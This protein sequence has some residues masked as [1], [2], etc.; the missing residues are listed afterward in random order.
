[1]SLLDEAST[2]GVGTSSASAARILGYLRH[3]EHGHTLLAPHD[4]DQGVL[5]SAYGTGERA[6]EGVECWDGADVVVAADTLRAR[7]HP[8]QGP[9]ATRTS[10]FPIGAPDFSALQFYRDERD[11]SSLAPRLSRSQCP[12]LWTSAVGPPEGCDYRDVGSA[13]E[14]WPWTYGEDVEAGID[15]DAEWR[16]GVEMPELALLG[17]PD[18]PKRAPSTTMMRPPAATTRTRTGV[19]EG[20]NV[21]RTRGCPE[22]SRDEIETGGGARCYTLE[23]VFVFGDVC[24][25]GCGSRCHERRKRYT[26]TDGCGG[27]SVYTLQRTYSISVWAGV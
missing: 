17:E 4:E 20:A 25:Y 21:L 10:H 18:T 6:E 26:S 8:S 5:S 27:A 12:L 16:R 13:L 22:S 15:V 24:G 19:A 9:G 7:A 23:S 14:G 11:V 3:F 1:M 2:K